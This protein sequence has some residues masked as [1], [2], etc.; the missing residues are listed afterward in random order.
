M[1]WHNI[2]DFEGSEKILHDIFGKTYR[3]YNTKSEP[4]CNLW[5]LGD[6][7]VSM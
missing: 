3:M 5:T 1:N 6:S 7:N 2:Q 4:S